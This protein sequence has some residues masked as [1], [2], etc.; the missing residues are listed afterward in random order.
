MRI[1]HNIQALRALNDS[2]KI[3][4]KSESHMAKIGSGTAIN[5]AADDAADLSISEGMRA[6]IRGL[7]QADQNI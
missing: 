3:M 1:N 5:K 4:K 2:S 6:Q 7:V